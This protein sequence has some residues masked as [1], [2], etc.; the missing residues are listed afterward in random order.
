MMRFNSTKSKIFSTMMLL[1]FLSISAWSQLQNPVDLAIRHLQE[2]KT[3]W[4]LTEAD[5]ADLVVSNNYVSSASGAS[6]VYLMQRYQGVKV[7]N[8]IYN[9]GISK[10]GKVVHAASRIIPN[11]VNKVGASSSPSLTP[12]A[13]IASA[14]S[15]LNVAM[16]DVVVQKERKNDQEFVFEKGAYSNTEI[17]VNLQF[18]PTNENKVE[19]AWEVEID[20]VSNSDYWNV[21]V[22]AKTGNVL[23]KHNYTTYCTFAQDA[24]HNH[25]AACR[26]LDNMRIV[27]SAAKTTAAPSVLLGGSYAVFAEQTADGNLHTHESPS[28]G[29]RNL[30]TGIEDLTASPYGWHDTN[31]QNGAEYTITRG[32]NVHAYLDLNGSDV[33]Q[34]DEPDGGAELLF[35]FSIDLDAE[36][37][38]FQAASV[39][40]GFFMSN[41]MHD[42]LYVYGFDE[43]AGNFQANNYG[44]GGSGN[45]Y[46]NMHIDDGSGINNANMSTPGDG[47]NPR[48]QMFLWNSTAASGLLTV[49]EP[50]SVAGIYEVAHPG[51]WGGQIDMTPL[52]AEVAIVD[53]G[54]GLDGSKGCNDLV[55]ITEV[56]GKIAIVD[57]GLCQ[58]SQKALMAQNAGAV[59]VIICNFEDAPPPLG[60]G[61]AALQ[62]TIPVIGIGLGL[63]TDLRAFAGNGLSLTF[64]EQPTGSGPDNISGSLDNGIIAHEYGHGISNRLVGGGNNTGC[65]GNGEQMGEGIS[66]FFSLVTTVKPGDTGEMGRGIGTFAQREDT[67]GGGIRRYPY[68]T[69]MSVNPLTY[70]DI[71]GQAAPHPIGEIWTLCLWEMYWSLVD[72]YGFDEDLFNGAG[73]NNIAV[74]LAIEG[75]KLTSCNPGYEDARNGV[76]AADQ[77]MYGGA[78]QCLIWAAFAKRGVGENADQASSDD[79]NDG[80]EN[81]ERPIDCLDEIQI[82]KTVNELINPG[83]DIDVLIEIK[84]YKQSVSTNVTVTDEIPDGAT[85]LPSS[86]VGSATVSGNTIT[87]VIGEMATQEATQ[88][89]YTLETDPSIKSIATFNDDQEGDPD[90]NWDIE[91]LNG[92]AIFDVRDDSLAYSGETAWFVQDA[93]V[94]NDQTL[95]AKSP[96]A[97]TGTQPVLRFYHWYDTEAGADGGLLEVSK[98]GGVL[99][100]QVGSSMFRHKYPRSLQYGTLVIPFLS[101]FSGQSS[102]GG[103]DFVATYVDMSDYLGEDI[104]FRFRFASDDNTSGKGWFIDDVT[105]M[106]MR[107]YEGVAC[108][109]TEQGDNNCTSVEER[110]TAVNPEETVANKNLFKTN[111]EVNVFPNPAQDILNIQVLN[112]KSA[113]AAV[114]ILTVDGKEMMDKSFRVVDGLQ[115]MSV[116]VARLPAGM[117][118]VKVSTNQGIVVEKVMIK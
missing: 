44:N 118:F 43:A 104:L 34:N 83:E 55:N 28:H 49:N 21:K 63:C 106:D 40:N 15:H 54:N 114:R 102:A 107:N 17:K 61:D 29:D 73:G 6:M 91:F 4:N 3:Q 9:V 90:E 99:W 103:E 97:V 2:N 10:E 95:F 84:N 50:A 7:Y 69:D 45:D 32:N 58:F 93:A 86:I 36:P 81:F 65:L 62:V 5:I 18:Y 30:L 8:A 92:A 33:S 66:D 111:M 41:V 19:L 42:F 108:V 52:T 76:L 67:D 57:R 60:A 27:T 105:F 96:I 112:D 39:T 78:N 22:D 77:L 26:S 70:K 110:G 51:D 79:A 94:E 56:T 1:M 64:V 117:Y 12:E 23:G 89:S 53:D 113:D 115:T 109:S 48:M 14:L 100:E 116:N 20:M 31:G 71:A 82:T 98:D 38:S 46:V 75:M 25:D 16:G 72:E 35:D 11:I 68:S 24:Y 13:A 85:V 101:A 37:E 74:S 80:V 87:F 47:S 59:G 88:V